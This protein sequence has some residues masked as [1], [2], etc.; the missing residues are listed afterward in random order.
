VSQILFG[1]PRAPIVAGPLPL[2]AALYSVV[3]WP[4]IEQFTYIGYSLPNL[5]KLF[6]NK[7]LAIT[8]TGLL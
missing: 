5:E 6:K 8:I 7:T 4:I 2:W 3:I 1:N